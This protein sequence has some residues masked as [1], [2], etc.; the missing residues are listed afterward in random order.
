MEILPSASLA[1]Y[2]KNYTIVT[3][4]QNLDNEVFYPSGYVD[5]I[6]NISEG[7][8][9]TIINGKRKDTP[10]IELLGHLTLPTRLTVAKG[11]SVLIARIYPH[12]SAL[13]F[14]D[15]VS[16]FTN[17]ATD[18]YDVALNENRELYSRIM[19]SKELN[20][21]INILETYFLQQLKKNESQLK[22]VLIVKAINQQILFEQEQLN[23]PAL[24]KHSGLSERY[25]Q[26]LYLSNIGISPAA[27]TSVVRF[28]KSLQLVLNTSQSLTEIAYDCGYYD[29]AH[30]IKEFRKFT[31]ITPSS[32]RSSL[33]KNDTDFQQAVNIGF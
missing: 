27:F 1:P 12:A 11:T 14:S 33:I 29:Q 5:F 30:F 18:M 7:A 21:K 10:E 28:N 6:I 9:A 8:A 19:E 16:E 3:I 13:F 25:I 32:S 31:G 20:S 4:N 15:H 24:A 17:Y 26:K 23:L 22:K 2:I